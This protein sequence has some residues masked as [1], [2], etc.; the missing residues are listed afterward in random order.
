MPIV[1]DLQRWVQDTF[2]GGWEVQQTAGIPEAAG[3]RLNSNHVKDLQE[4]VNTRN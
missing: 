2:T 4:A 1:D 3:L